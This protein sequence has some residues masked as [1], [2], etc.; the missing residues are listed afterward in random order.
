MRTRHISTLT[1]SAD[2]SGLWCI[3]KKLKCVCLYAAVCTHIMECIWVSL[4]PCICMSVRWY[5]FRQMNISQ[6]EKWLEPIAERWTRHGLVWRVFST[7]YW[8]D[9]RLSRVFVWVCDYVCKFLFPWYRTFSIYWR[10]D[11]ITLESHLQTSSLSASS[12]S[13]SSSYSGYN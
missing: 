7:R 6:I 9:L 3:R 11:L 5:A 8:I 13:T 4:A 10:I 12:T 2:Y 1:A